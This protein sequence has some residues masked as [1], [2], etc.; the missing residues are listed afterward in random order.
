[1]HS[2][3]RR[4]NQ[5]LPP[6][7]GDLPESVNWAAVEAT[8]GSAFPRDFQ[9]FMGIYGR[10]TIDN[11]FTIATPVDGGHMQ[12]VLRCRELTPNISTECRIDGREVSYPA[13]PHNGGL[14]GW[15]TTGIGIDLFWSARGDD[16]DLWPLVIRNRR[17][18]SAQEIPGGMAAFLVEM[19][20]QRKNRP[21][22]IPDIIGFPYSRFIGAR[23]EARLEA[24]GVDP[25]EYLDEY[26]EVDD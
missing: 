10:G 21:L 12:G 4:L 13:W 2:S 9:E 11:V 5:V 16:A 7:A 8:W 15:A 3:L 1:M 19:L 24:A 23:E 18:G 26:D 14:I 6:S 25:W 17:G 20:G 22:D